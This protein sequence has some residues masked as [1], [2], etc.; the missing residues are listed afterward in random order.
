[1]T[2]V[3]YSSLYSDVHSVVGTVCSS[4]IMLSE[5]GKSY[6]AADIVCKGSEEARTNV[7]CTDIGRELIMLT[8]NKKTLKLPDA[9]ETNEPNS[10]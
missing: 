8:V 10:S 9:F 5:D 7:N 6:S 2:D 4:V 1:M 3:I